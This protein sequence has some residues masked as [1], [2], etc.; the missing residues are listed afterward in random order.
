MRRI[1][2]P[3]PLLILWALPLLASVG[4]AFAGLFDLQAWA[5]LL[6]HP[7]SGPGLRLSLATASAST[8][9]AVLLALIIL[10]GFHRTPAWNRLQATS[11]AGLSLPH[12]SFAIGLGFLIMPSGFV[13]RLVA[14]GDAPPQ[15]ISVHDPSGVSLSLALAL[16]EVPFLVALG[17]SALSQG[18]M[19]RAI[20]GQVRAARSLGHGAGSVWLRIVQPQALRR[21]AWP[22]VIV[23]AYGASVVDM[24]IA[25]GPTQPPVLAVVIW[26]DLNDADAAVNARGLAGSLLLTGAIACAV[27]VTGICLRLLR[28]ASRGFLAAGPS[29][30]AAPA[31]FSLAVGGT[32]AVVHVAVAISLAVMSVAARWPYPLLLPERFGA[33]AWLT[34]VQ[35]SSSLGTSVAVSAAAAGTA[36]ALAVAWFESAPQ[37][38]DRWLIG[39]CLLSLALPQL[40]IAAGQYRLFLALDLTGT[41]AG[42]FLAHLTPVMG[43]A[44]IVLAG[45]YR[46]F[47]ERY[48]RAASALKAPYW[49]SWLTIKAPLLRPALLTAA[50]VGFAVSIMQYVPAALMGAGRF[51]TLPIDAV[52][53]TSG[54]DRALTAAYALAL[55]TP[56]LLAFLLAGFLGRPRWR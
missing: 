7:Q 12:L 38:L 11:A 2:G 32:I 56:P 18:D 26:R 36:L 39:L 13:A 3:L 23:F 6:R 17:W 48:I 10:A 15:W 40:V 46:G 27:A 28:P 24:A 52:T 22:I 53:L 31:G 47:D 4:L 50:A 14:G 21:L 41:P 37:A 16:K 45:P 35:G 42:V 51:T 43:Y 20:E 5:A 30:A 19:A 55:A 1:S 29:A 33:G 25:I 54:G 8:L 44:V 49:R 9:L 34:M